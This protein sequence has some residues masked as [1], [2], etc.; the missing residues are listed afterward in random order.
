MVKIHIKCKCTKLVTNCVLV[1]IGVF[2]HM[3]SY[4]YGTYSAPQLLE[5]CGS[6]WAV[7]VTYNYFTDYVVV[8]LG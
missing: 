3:E 7:F 4:K 8:A 5:L 6:L 2:N 1:S